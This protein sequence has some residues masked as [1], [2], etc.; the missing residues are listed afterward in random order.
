MTTTAE[1]RPGH[2]TS[3]NRESDVVSHESSSLPFRRWLEVQRIAG[4]FYW[5]INPDQPDS[6]DKVEIE[7]CTP[8]N[9]GHIPELLIPMDEVR[10][11]MR[12]DNNGEVG[13]EDLNCP[14]DTTVLLEGVGPSN[15]LKIKISNGVA[16][17]GILGHNRHGKLTHE[18]A[19][20]SFDGSPHTVVALGKVA[21]VAKENGHDVF[22]RDQK[23]WEKVESDY[24]WNHGIEKEQD[25]FIASRASDNPYNDGRVFEIKAY[26]NG[27]LE[28][29]T[30]DDAGSNRNKMRIS[31]VIRSGKRDPDYIM[32]L[33]NTRKELEADNRGDTRQIP[34][35]LD[36]EAFLRG[37]EPDSFIQ[38][39]FLALAGQVTVTLFGHDKTGNLL[40]TQ[41]VFERAK[42][43]NT[44]WGLYGAAQAA[45]RLQLRQEE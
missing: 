10:I 18:K 21:Q 27:D 6:L 2:T 4:D 26:K 36:L 40:Q 34:S 33:H 3:V 14:E 25:H 11:G 31:S 37:D 43:P 8:F 44:Y 41:V 15:R 35:H 32:H 30:I 7:F 45:K 23:N 24:D 16:E 22:K 9:G 13:A 38:F 20:Y 28:I 39:D 1:T 17:V 29:S 12:N 5:S 19:F 42:S